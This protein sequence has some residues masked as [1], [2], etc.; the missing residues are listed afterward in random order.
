MTL[1]R[2]QAVAALVMA[3]TALFLISVAPG[4]RYRREARI[5]AVTAFALALGAALV[6]SALWLAGVI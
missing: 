5:A 6:W 4:M 1:D 3:A 2:E